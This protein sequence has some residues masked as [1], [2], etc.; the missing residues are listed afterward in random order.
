[1]NLKIAL[2]GGIIFYL[3]QFLLG[4]ITGPLLHEG[5]LDPYYQQTAAFW[6][7][8]LMQDPPDMAALMPRWITTGVIFAIIIA[9]IYSM[10]R[11]S[12]SG[13]GLLKGIKY[14]V[15][16]TV[17]MAGWSAAWSGIFNLPDA[18]WLWWTAES[19]LYFVVAG[20]VLGWVSAKLVPE[21]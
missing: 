10:V 18:I 5:I 6:R 1:M 8:E 16:L 12:F 19:V 20:A 3:V 7:P 9:G 17:L 13:S 4:M 21:S 2:I 11:S 15:M 14:G